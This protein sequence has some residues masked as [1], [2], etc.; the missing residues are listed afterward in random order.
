[1]ANKIKEKI[2]GDAKAAKQTPIMYLPRTWSFEGNIYNYN[3]SIVPEKTTNYSD[4]IKTE[5]GKMTKDLKY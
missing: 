4:N 2:Y 3:D 5:Q 1:M